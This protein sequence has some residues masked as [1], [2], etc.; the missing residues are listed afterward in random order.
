[1][2]ELIRVADLWERQ[3][4]NREPYIVGAMGGIKVLL[5]RRH[6]APPEGPH[7]T[8]FFAPRP[9]RRDQSPALREGRGSRMMTIETVG[10][11]RT[12]KRPVAAQTT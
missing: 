6:D 12:P 7:W 5:F 10:T 11:P 2:G 3:T 8:L 1:M 4:R 9:E